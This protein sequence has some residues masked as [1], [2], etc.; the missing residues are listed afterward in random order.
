[1]C[2]AKAAMA[3]ES[4]GEGPLAVPDSS[5]SESESELLLV[6]SDALVPTGRLAA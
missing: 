6:P 2:D 3:G 1:M 4:A 5:E